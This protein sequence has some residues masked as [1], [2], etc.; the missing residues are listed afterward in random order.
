MLKLIASNFT[1]DNS[2]LITDRELGFNVEIMTR[3]GAKSSD[4]WLTVG[5][6][7]LFID[8]DLK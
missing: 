8:R 5:Y 2:F 6:V 7:K 3:F 1:A 4:M